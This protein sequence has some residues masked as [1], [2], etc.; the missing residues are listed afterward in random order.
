MKFKK[1]AEHAVS[2]KIKNVL[3]K[4]A[5]PYDT[6]SGSVYIRFQSILYSSHKRIDE[7]DGQQC[8]I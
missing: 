5:K 8:K 6:K 7:C 1:S 2:E 4:K 3:S